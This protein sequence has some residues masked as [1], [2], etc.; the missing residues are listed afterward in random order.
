MTK[1]KKWAI[2][3][4][5][6]YA[7]MIFLNYW[8]ATDVGSVADQEQAI[9]Q[10]A[11]FAFSIWGLIYVLLL[12]WIIRLFFINQTE[13][14]VAERITFWPILNFAL[15]GSWI[16]AF[17]QQWLFIST[18][19]I[20]ALLITLIIMYRRIS[21]M[22]DIHWFDRLP[23]SI[24]FAWVTVATIVNIFTWFVGMGVTEFL[25]LSELTWTNILLIVATGI[26]IY[27]SIKHRDWLYPLV[28]VWSYTAIFV[29]N[30]TDYTSLM[31]VLIICLIIQL[32]TAIWA[33][34][35][36]ITGPSSRT[37]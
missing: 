4:L 13:D 17:T 35:D 29:E 2:A 27:V 18:L 7:L 3:Y 5:I 36:K 25:G 11:G 12:I 37:A 21:K 14:T 16:I 1:T 24:Y 28:F 8:S 23:I 9:I 19:I 33:G 10:P 22:N 15:N 30:Q 6:A 20:V 32:G 26:M 31:I 34:Y